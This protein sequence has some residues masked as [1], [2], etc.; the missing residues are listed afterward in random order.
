[1]SCTASPT[2]TAPT[3]AQFM[4]FFFRDFPYAGPNTPTTDLNFVQPQDINNA[5][6]IA[7]INFSAGMFDN[8]GISTTVFMYLAAF[9]LVENLKNSAK[10]I[11]AQA[12][13]PLTGIGAGGVNLSMEVPES[14]KKNPIYSMYCRNAYGLNYLSIVYPY[15]IG[16]GT[17]VDGTSTFS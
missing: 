9:Y 6:A 13:F 7:Q 1:M 8:N 17:L 14:F 2:W 16:A 11:A 3:A 10:G 5:I 12:N 15:T 4:S